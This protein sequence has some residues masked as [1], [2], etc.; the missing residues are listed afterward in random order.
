MPILE[1][2]MTKDP[3]FEWTECW[4]CGEPAMKNG[5]FTAGCPGCDP[6][7]PLCEKAS[8]VD[9][10]ELLHPELREYAAMDEAMIYFEEALARR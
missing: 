10:Q 6:G 1:K 4:G 9:T 2:A 5:P 7:V 3:V 8:D